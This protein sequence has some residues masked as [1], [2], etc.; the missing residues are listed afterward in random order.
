MRM[1][2]QAGLRIKERQI[3]GLF[4]LAISYYKLS[5]LIKQ[6]LFAAFRQQFYL[7]WVGYLG[8]VA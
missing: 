7:N 1:L 3:G 2:F 5:A 6:E 4:C 8:S